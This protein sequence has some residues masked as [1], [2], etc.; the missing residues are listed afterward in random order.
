MKMKL[1][2]LNL[3]IGTLLFQ[4]CIAKE[5]QKETRIVTD[6]VEVEKLVKRLIKVMETS[7]VHLYMSVAN[8]DLDPEKA[9]SIIGLTQAGYIDK[10][11]NEILAKHFK[12]HPLSADIIYDK[13]D[14]LETKKVCDY[15][16]LMKIPG[17][18][19]H[20]LIFFHEGNYISILEW[21]QHKK[22]SN[23]NTQKILWPDSEKMLFRLCTF[24]QNV[25]EER[26]RIFF[27][28]LLK[29]RE[30]ENNKK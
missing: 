28:N 15:R 30:A 20:Y 22:L 11:V 7:D 21:D 26:K 12:T 18:E 10:G 14:N 2:L 4:A 25:K 9:N 27:E 6:K 29:E 24:A 5:A 8:E 16:G 17:K 1:T 3:I 19:F 13:K 23:L